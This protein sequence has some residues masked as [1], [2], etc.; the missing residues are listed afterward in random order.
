MGWASVQGSVQLFRPTLGFCPWLAFLRRARA[1]RF[2][3]RLDILTSDYSGNA[4]L[5]R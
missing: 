3:V 2:W 4:T 1:L 5:T